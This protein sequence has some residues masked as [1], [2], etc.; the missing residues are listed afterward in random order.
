M[1]RSEPSV[2]AIFCSGMA[3]PRMAADE[4]QRGV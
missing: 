1:K 4:M 3:R 2:G